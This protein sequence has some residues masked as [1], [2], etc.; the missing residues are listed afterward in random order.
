M[1]LRPT[2]TS[3]TGKTKGLTFIEIFVVIIIISILAGVSIPQFRKTY[4]NFVLD[5]SVKDIYYLCQ[6]L[7]SSA[8]SQAKIHLLKINKD[9]SPVQFNASYQVEN[10]DGGKS[11][12]AVEGRFGRTYTAPE[13]VIVYSTEPPNKTDVYFYPDGSTDGITVVFRNRYDKQISLII[14]GASGGIKIE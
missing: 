9:V 10:E 14:K 8:I 12:K 11:D 3:A 2:M 5:N 6:F 7:Q 1:K 13:G 4:G